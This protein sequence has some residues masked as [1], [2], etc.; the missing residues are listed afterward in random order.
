M[1]D[2]SI[3]VTINAV[4]RVKAKSAEEAVKLVNT[5]LDCAVL[6]MDPEDPT[7]WL[8]EATLTDDVGLRHVF[9]RDGE[10]L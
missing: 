7:L 2:Y 3:F 8:N 10:E 6:N 1:A 5:R 9:E 4:A